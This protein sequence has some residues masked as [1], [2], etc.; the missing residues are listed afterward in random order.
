MISEAAGR[1]LKTGYKTCVFSVDLNPSP[2]PL[3]LSSPRP[4]PRQRSKGTS[5]L[6]TA[7][8]GHGEKVLNLTVFHRRPR[9]HDPRTDCF[10]IVE[11]PLTRWD[12]LVVPALSLCRLKSL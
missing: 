2:P 12:H 5:L 4:R 10:Y 8:R 6:S 1:H 7:K 11:A 3:L 9:T